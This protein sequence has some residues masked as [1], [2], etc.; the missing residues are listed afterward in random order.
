MRRIL[1][2]AALATTMAGA[3]AQTPPADDPRA[4]LRIH[5]AVVDRNGSPVTD[6]RPDEFEV[7]INIFRVPIQ[8][9]TVVS[10]TSERG[11]TIALLL[12]DLAIDHAMGIRV[13]EAARQFVTRMSPG[14]RMAIVALNGS[15]TKSTDDRTQLLRTIDAY[16]PRAL[17]LIPFEDVGPHVL[18]TIASLSRQFSEVAGPKTIVG[19]G[20]AWLFDRPV[21]PQ[22]I[23]RDVRKEWIEAVRAMAFADASLYV[24]DPGGVGASPFASGGSGGFARETGGHA[25]ENSNDVKGTVDRIMREAANY[26]VLEVADPPV[27]RKAELR[28]LDVRVKRRGA[29]VR[30]RRWIPG[31]R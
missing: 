4:P 24:L 26:Y 18:N 27:G 14:D 20:A 1:I 17:G 29:S 28:E 30:A 23:G 10:P 3:G 21:Q 12:D 31:T 19:I 8:T 25:F 13:K 2:T 11:R 9:V 22:A 5:A 7:W 16:N 6:L 15:A